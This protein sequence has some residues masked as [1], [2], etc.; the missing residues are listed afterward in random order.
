MTNNSIAKTESSTH[1]QISS[2][3]RVQINLPRLWEGLG[4]SERKQILKEIQRIS[5]GL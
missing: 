5:V 3:W 2:Q 4:R 1:Q